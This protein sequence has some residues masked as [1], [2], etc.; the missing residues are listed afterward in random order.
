[1]RYLWWL[2]PLAMLLVAATTPEQNDAQTCVNNILASYGPGY[3]LNDGEK[4]GCLKIGNLVLD[5]PPSCL[6]M[7]N[8]KRYCVTNGLVSQE[9]R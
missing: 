9:M 1:M 7:R 6:T 5:D 2:F 4:A 8:S 3:L